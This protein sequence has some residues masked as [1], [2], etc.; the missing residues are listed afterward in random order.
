MAWCRWE[1][2]SSVELEDLSDGGVGEVGLVPVGATQHHGHHLPI[3]TDSIVARAVCAAASDRCGAP[4]LPAIDLGC[5]VGSPGVGTLSLAPEQLTSLA[6]RWV[7]EA[8][9]SGLRALLFV[10]AHPG[11]AAALADAVD[12]G[13]EVGLE[14]RVGV[15]HWWALDATV[16]AECAAD[17]GIHGGRAE[18]ALLLAVAPELVRL[19]RLGPSHRLAGV[20]EALGADLLARTAAALAA[21]VEQQRAA[22]RPIGLQTTL[23]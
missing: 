21:E 9:A 16:A 18:T 17:P 23:R 1:E 2:L 6:R 3:G 12:P 5:A 4:V 14:A 13:G 20:T 22:R 8:T 15:A 7:A 10:N 11:N 19:D